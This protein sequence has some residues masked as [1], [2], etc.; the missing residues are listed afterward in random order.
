MSTTEVDLADTI[1]EF[2]I[3]AYEHVIY[4]VGKENSTLVYKPVPEGVNIFRL[5]EMKPPEGIDNLHN[6]T[7]ATGENSTF[8]PM[9]LQAFQVGIVF[10]YFPVLRNRCQYHI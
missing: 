3:N 8:M 6:W 4:V 1:S 10:D 9:L 2:I 5:F 7:V